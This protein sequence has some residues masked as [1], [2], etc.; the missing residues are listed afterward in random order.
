MKRHAKSAL[1]ASV[2]VAVLLAGISFAA[3]QSSVTSTVSSTNS[4]ES[5]LALGKTIYVY[6]TD[7]SGK[8]IPRSGFNGMMCVTATCAYCHGDDAR[9]RTIQIMMSQIQTPDIR[10]STLTATPSEPGDVAF[11]PDSFFHAVTQG[12]DPTG[13]IL[14]TYMPRWQLTRNEIDAVIEYLKTR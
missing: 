7:A 2:M 9:G 8:T 3:C 14:E 13:A 6:G 1:N 4:T 5:Q 10:W 12:I 11:D